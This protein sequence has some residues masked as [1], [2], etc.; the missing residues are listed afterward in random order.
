MK[1][2]FTTIP[3]EPPKTRYPWIGISNGRLIVFH[4]AEGRGTVLIDQTGQ[5]NS[6]FSSIWTESAYIPFYGTITVERD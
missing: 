6:G 5:Y 3:A 2:T 4:G 1:V